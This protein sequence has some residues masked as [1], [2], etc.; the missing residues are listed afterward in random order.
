MSLKKY[1][2]K[3]DLL[4]DN[5][6]L[7]LEL[8]SW[9]TAY[10]DYDDNYWDYNYTCDNCGKPYC[11]DYEY[12]QDYKYLPSMEETIIYLNRLRWKIVSKSPYGKW[13]ISEPSLYGNFIDMESVYGKVEIRN[14][15]IDIVLGLREPNYSQPVTIGDF[16]DRIDKNPN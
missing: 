16:F 4:S 1:K 5:F 14:R 6:D 7:E 15:R 3:R 9:Y 8:E 10:W 13:T 2:G 12:C 11:Q